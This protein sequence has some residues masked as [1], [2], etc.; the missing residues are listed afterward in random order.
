[1]KLSI[2]TIAI[3]FALLG[4]TATVAH[5][6]IGQGYIDSAIRSAHSGS[7]NVNVF[8][9]GN[10]ATL[11]GWIEDSQSRAQVLAAAHKLPGVDTVNGHIF[12]SN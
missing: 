6:N 8:V 3:T 7:G 1:M 12:V 5:A 9:N 11:S 4:S 10:T 2:K